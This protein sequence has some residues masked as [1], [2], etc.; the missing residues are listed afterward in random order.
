MQTLLCA[1][2]YISICAHVKDPVVHVKVRSIMETLKHPICSVGWVT[3]LC[4]SWLSSG[5]AT[6]FSHGRS[7]NRTIQLLKKIMA[8]PVS[9]QFGVGSARLSYLNFSSYA[10][11]LQPLIVLSRSTTHHPA[12]STAV[13]SA[14]EKK[15]FLQIL[16][17]D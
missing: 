8:A 14:Y 10:S 16:H 1:I 12:L 15:T 6:R 7:P 2:A 17:V 5:K 11:C 9:D 3:R 4:Y 13:C